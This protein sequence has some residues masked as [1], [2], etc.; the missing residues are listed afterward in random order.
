MV[1]LDETGEGR[2]QVGYFRKDVT[3]ADAPKEAVLHLFADSR[4]VLL[5]NGTTLGT[6][7]VRF[8]PENPFYDTYD[9]RSYL[10]KGKN[11]I[12]VKVLSQGMHTFQTPRSLGGFTAWGQI[13]EASGDKVALDVPRGW[14]CRRA[15]GYD[16]TTPKMTFALGAMEVF[17]ARQYPDDWYESAP[18]AGWNAPVVLQNQKH[19]GKMQPRPIPFLT[20]STVMPKGVAVLVKPRGRLASMEL[21]INGKKR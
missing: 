13:T 17:D 18:A 14:R 7:P 16:A 5:V 21:W 6:G 4:Y 10:Q 8:Y 11:V 2:M 3:L 20:Q 1:W 9:I 15:G 19:W 12:A